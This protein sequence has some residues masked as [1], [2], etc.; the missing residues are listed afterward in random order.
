MNGP[1]GAEGF[2]RADV[3]DTPRGPRLGVAGA[4]LPMKPTPQVAWALAE[5]RREGHLAQVFAHVRRAGVVV[6][7][8]RLVEV[9][10]T[11]R[12]FSTGF[13]IARFVLLVALATVWWFVFTETAGMKLD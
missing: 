9:P 6:V 1:P 13:A 5:A 4:L 12:A 11:R 2:V 10:G 3:I 7:C 8:D